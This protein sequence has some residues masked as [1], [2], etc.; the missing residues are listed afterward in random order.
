MPTSKMMAV[1]TSMAV[2]SLFA[3][4]QAS[5][6]MEVEIEGAE[7][8][9]TVESAMQECRA[10]GGRFE[11]G[12]LAC[13]GLTL[14]MKVVVN[15][16]D[17]P[18]GKVSSGVVEN[19]DSRAR[20]TKFNGP[21]L[22]ARTLDPANGHVYIPCGF[23]RR[24]NFFPL[25][26]KKSGPWEEGNDSFLRMETKLYPSSRCRGSRLIRAARRGTRRCTT[27]GNAPSERT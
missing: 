15:V 8:P 1:I 16:R 26:G 24:L 10:Y 7:R 13:D 22:G 9:L 19:N 18:D 4:K 14:D 17:T 5:W 6:T 21:N 2:G 20:V 23:G 12:P 3:A 27:Q 11:Y 25:D